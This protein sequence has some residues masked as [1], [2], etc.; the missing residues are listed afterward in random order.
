MTNFEVNGVQYIAVEVP[1]GKMG[2]FILAMY[3][4]IDIVSINGQGNHYIASLPTGRW[5]IVGL[6]KDIDPWKKHNIMDKASPFTS[7]MAWEDLNLSDNH[8][9]IKQ[10]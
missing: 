4:D 7:W 5:G 3:G 9:I 8:L 6:V 10:L 2:K 1:V